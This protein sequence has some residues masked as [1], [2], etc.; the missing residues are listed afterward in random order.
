MV[1]YLYLSKVLIF[2]FKLHNDPSSV[3]K[4]GDLTVSVYFRKVKWNRTSKSSESSGRFF[5]S[6]ANVIY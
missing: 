6:P 2:N 1:L 3:E 5:N 4:L